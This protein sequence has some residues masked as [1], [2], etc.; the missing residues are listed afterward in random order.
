MMTPQENGCLFCTPPQCPMTPATRTPVWRFDSSTRPPLPSR[1][2]LL[3]LNHWP[4]TPGRFVPS[5]NCHPRCHGQSITD[6]FVGE[7]WG[8]NYKQRAKKVLGPFVPEIR[9]VGHCPQQT[10]CVWGQ[11]TAVCFDPRPGILTLYLQA[12]LTRLAGVL[13]PAWLALPWTA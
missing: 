7:H 11:Q 8:L 1:L 13:R 3:P 5:K 4:F 9:S 6:E 2:L 12:L 10:V